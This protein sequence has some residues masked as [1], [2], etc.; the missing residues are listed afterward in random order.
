[1]SNANDAPPPLFF[2]PMAPCGYSSIRLIRASGGNKQERGES[3]ATMLSIALDPTVY[4]F[5]AAKTAQLNQ[6]RSKQ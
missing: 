5:F 4:R 6:E 3:L 1:M 2:V